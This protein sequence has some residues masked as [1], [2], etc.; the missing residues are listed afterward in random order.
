[1]KIKYIFIIIVMM[2]ASLFAK[3]Y[4]ELESTTVDGLKLSVEVSKTYTTIFVD[5][6]IPDKPIPSEHITINAFLQNES[7][8]KMVVL[9]GNDGRSL[10]D[11]GIVFFAYNFWP[12][13]PDAQVKPRLND[14]RPIELN[15]GEI[16]ALPCFQ[17]NEKSHLSK[18]KVCYNID[19]EFAKYYNDV[20]IGD[21][22]FFVTVPH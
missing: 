9:L 3:S 11:G 14:F 5:G 6:T 4:S 7:N 18:I 12:G 16:A 22:M 19:K 10:F 13:Y 2:S 8:K 17:F 1:M 15:P 20:W 21:I